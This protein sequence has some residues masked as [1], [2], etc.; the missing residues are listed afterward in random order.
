MRGPDG[1][2]AGVDV[3]QSWWAKRDVLYKVLCGRVFDQEM[4]QAG[5]PI[6]VRV[7]NLERLYSTICKCESL[8]LAERTAMIKMLAVAARGPP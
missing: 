6:Q 4:I 3:I 2:P 7:F 1:R 5:V 8:E